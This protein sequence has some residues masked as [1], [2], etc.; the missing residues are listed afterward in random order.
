MPF[1]S[2]KQRR[3]LFANKPTLAKEFASKTKNIKGL[4]E[5][6]SPYL[7]AKRKRGL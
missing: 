7:N 4:P 6:V 5:K 2:Q 3:Y 1:V